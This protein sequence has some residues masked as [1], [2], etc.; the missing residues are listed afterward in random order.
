MNSTPGLHELLKPER[1][2]A[3]V[4]IGANPRASDGLP[5]YKV[6]LDLGICTIVGFEPQADSYAMLEQ[7]K[8]D[9]ETYLP[10]A[11][12]DGGPGVLNVCAALGMTSLLVPDPRMLQCFQG[13]SDYGQVVETANIETR[14]L[15]SIDEITALDFLKIDIQGGELAAIRGGARKLAAAVAIQIEVSFMPLYRNQPVF[16]DID[17]ALRALGF[18]PHMFVNINKRMILPL[19]DNKNQFGAMNQLLEADIVYVKDFSQPLSMTVEQLKHLALVS[20]HCYS[21]YDLATNCI[22]QLAQRG[23]VPAD[24]VDQYLRMLVQQPG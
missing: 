22:H 7:K 3:A 10:Y 19:R 20:H 17:L 16:G 1:L 23:A 9:R 2:T 8:N 11:I 24:A 21:S 18:V 4:D 5:P 6:L 13:F 15:D 12:G 14:T